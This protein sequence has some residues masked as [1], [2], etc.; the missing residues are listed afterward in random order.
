MDKNAPERLLVI[1]SRLA[2]QYQLT[3][4]GIKNLQHIFTSWFPKVVYFDLRTRV[5]IKYP[6]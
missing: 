1:A 6:I 3:E 2:D 5:K 4:S